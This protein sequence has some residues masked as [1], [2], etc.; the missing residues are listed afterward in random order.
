MQMD[1]TAEGINV[2]VV[3]P[4]TEIIEITPEIGE[5]PTPTPTPTLPGANPSIDLGEWFIMVILLSGLSWLSYLFGSNVYSLRWGVRWGFITFIAGLFVYTLVVLLIPGGYEWFDRISLLGRSSLI[6]SGAGLGFLL[7]FA[8]KL[9]L[10]E[11]R[12]D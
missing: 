11:D 2:T 10:V 12:T 7:G 6:A 8:W 1:I 9:F 4:A 5:T 3:P